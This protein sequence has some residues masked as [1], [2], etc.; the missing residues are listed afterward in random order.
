M[1]AVYRLG[2]RQWASNAEPTYSV[3]TRMGFRS[4]NGTGTDGY[5]IAKKNYPLLS[6]LQSP[7]YILDV[8]DRT[9]FANPFLPGNSL[10]HAPEAC[11]DAACHML[12]QGCV[13]GEL[14]GACDL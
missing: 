12:F 13:A 11:P 5:S 6:E 4:D 1:A 3:G 2:Y 7:Y 10:D 9:L 8:E 14:I